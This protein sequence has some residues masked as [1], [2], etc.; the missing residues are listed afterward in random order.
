MLAVYRGSDI[1]GAPLAATLLDLFAL[2][3]HLLTADVCFRESP[4]GVPDLET[5]LV[6]LGGTRCFPLDLH[7]G[8]VGW[9]ASVVGVAE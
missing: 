8:F 9:V 4:T 3:T 2:V 5:G 7:C 1:G 6:I